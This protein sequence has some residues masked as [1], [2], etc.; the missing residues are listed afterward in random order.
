MTTT[1]E[2]RRWH[3]E[4]LDEENDPQP[5]VDYT[6]EEVPDYEGLEDVT[7]FGDPAE[8]DSDG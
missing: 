4:P 1:D 5:P 6:D 8:V 3:T 2:M 7:I